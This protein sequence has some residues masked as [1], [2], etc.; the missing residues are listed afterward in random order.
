[1]KTL[2]YLMVCKKLKKD[3]HLMKMFGLKSRKINVQTTETD[4][5][6]VLIDTDHSSFRM[7]LPIVA[8]F[9]V[10]GAIAHGSA[11]RFEACPPEGCAAQT[12]SLLQR[13]GVKIEAK[14]VDA[15]ALQE[16]DSRASP[17]SKHRDLHS[18]R[19]RLV[20]PDSD[21]W[22]PSLLED[23]MNQSANVSQVLA[24]TG[25]STPMRQKVEV[26]GPDGSKLTFDT[27][28]STRLCEEVTAAELPH[29]SSE[30]IA[31]IQDMFKSKPPSPKPV[32]ASSFGVLIVVAGLRKTYAQYS[33]AG[34]AQL[35]ANMVAAILDQDG[36]GVADDPDTLSKMRTGPQGHWV[37]LK[38]SGIRKERDWVKRLGTTVQI[39]EEHDF[40]KGMAIWETARNMFE[41]TYHNYQHAREKAFPQ[42][43]GLQGNC[44][45][46]P[47]TCT[48]TGSLA[49]KCGALAQCNWYRH[50]ECRCAKTGKGS[51]AADIQSGDCASPNCAG[52][53]WDYNVEMVLSDNAAMSHFGTDGGPAPGV[54]KN[55][56][57]IKSTLEAT[58]G[59]CTEF[60]AALQN[61][62]YH[63]LQ[64]RVTFG[65]AVTKD[66]KVHDDQEA[67]DH[68]DDDD[69]GDN[70][71][72]S[73]GDD[74]DDGTLP[75]GIAA[76]ENKGL[77]RR[78]CRAVGCC[79]FDAG[80]CWANEEDSC[81]A[82][83][84]GGGDP[85]GG[86]QKPGR[87]WW[88]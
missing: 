2:L 24:A 79:H 15:S 60:L 81:E 84:P 58:G 87:P 38:R 13:H 70:Q 35:A 53:E 20:T 1:M 19:H 51:S 12:S 31:K 74:D 46:S 76:C 82:R 9:L 26:Y 55:V 43:F 16:V 18:V 52:I 33:Q 72:Y 47:A 40:K 5:G 41:E 10:H 86:G 67:A 78:Q 17:P 44:A 77:T 14:S 49:Q 27:V 45:N 39:S 57:A 42:I 7:K 30:Y 63:I 25:S 11:D 37:H 66:G 29:L 22:T 59:V 69:A 8:A 4:S 83:S 34:F 36:D 48:W 85:G 3:L 75:A 65:S 64:K 56:A 54:W 6:L 73:G 88:R 23:A 68:H 71:Q 50:H 61:P 62:Q 28:F 21:G 80:Q 32:C